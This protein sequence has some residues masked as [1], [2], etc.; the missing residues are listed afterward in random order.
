LRRRLSGDPEFG[1]DLPDKPSRMHWRTYQRFVERIV[2]CEERLN[3]LLWQW[4]TA[5]EKRR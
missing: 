2:A 3:A 5:L 1:A 4:I